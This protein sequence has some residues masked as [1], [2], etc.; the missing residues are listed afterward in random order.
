MGTMGW[1]ALTITA[2]MYH[3]FPKIYNT[4]IYSIKLANIHFWLVFVAQLIYSLSLW[5]G[6]V[7]QGAMLKMTNSEGTLAYTFMDTLEQIYPFLHLRTLSGVIFTIGTVI[8]IVNIA[9]TIVKGKREGG[10]A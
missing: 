4:T 5:V 9:L 2:S 6:G 10:V 7:K 1:V 8:F 3:V